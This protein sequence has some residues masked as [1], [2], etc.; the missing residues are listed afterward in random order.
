MKQIHDKMINN[1]IIANKAHAKNF[2]N[3]EWD[4]SSWGGGITFFSGIKVRMGNKNKKLMNYNIAEFAKAYVWHE[5]FHDLSVAFRVL[6]LFRILEIAIVK[7][8]KEVKV[9]S[10]DHKVLDEVMTIVQENFAISTS[11]K[12]YLDLRVLCS[13]M[14]KNEMLPES[15]TRWSYPFKS[16][17]AYTNRTMDSMGNLSNQKKLPDEKA[18]DFIGKIFSSNPVNERDIFTSSIFALLLCAPSRISEIMLLEEDCEVIVEDSNGIS[19]YGLRFL[20]LKGF[21]YNTKW[22]PDCMVPVASKAIMR[23]KKLTR[24]ARV[25][26][27]LI[28]AGEINLYES[29]NRSAFDCLTIEDLHKLGFVINQLNISQENLKFLSKIKHGTVSVKAFWIYIKRKNVNSENINANL[30]SINHNLLE[31]IKGADIFTTIKASSKYFRADFRTDN[32]NNI[33]HRNIHFNCDGPVLI[34]RSHQ[35][36]HLLNT[37]AQRSVLSEIQIAQWSGRRSVKQNAVYDHMSHDELSELS[38]KLLNRNTYEE[39]KISES[40]F[41]EQSIIMNLIKDKF[42]KLELKIQNSDPR[43]IKYILEKI[44][45]LRLKIEYILM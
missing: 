14:S 15:I 31:S 16:Y 29:L 38:R 36:R 40:S 34:F 21:G 1:F 33:F 2:G 32:M 10:I 44:K 42:E 22:I 43:K 6:R 24:N 30:C 28:K 39:T 20:S 7:I 26:S 41:N 18:I 23:L 12:I 37:I 25:V 27:R 11:Y 13:F 5:C 19:R 3:F 45:D 8:N 35:I 9:S 17:D 4:N